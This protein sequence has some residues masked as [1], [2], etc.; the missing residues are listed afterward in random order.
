MS[1]GAPG[2]IFEKRDIEHVSRKRTVF[3][4]AQLLQQAIEV[5]RNSS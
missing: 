2:I 5:G 1:C 4:T 3:K